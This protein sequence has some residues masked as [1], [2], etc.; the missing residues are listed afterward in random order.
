MVTARAITRWLPAMVVLGLVLV[1]AYRVGNAQRGAS[2]ETE[3]ARQILEAS[4]VKGGLIVHVGCGDGRLTAALCANDSYVVH[5]L[6][7]N[8]GNIERAREHIRSL[9]LYGKVSVERRKGKRLPYVDNLVNL[10]VSDGRARVSM[11]EVMRVLCPNGVAYIKKGRKWTKAVKPRP[12]EIDAWTHYLHDA[13]NNAVAHDSVVGPPR[14]MQWVGSPRWARHHDRM[15]SLTALVSTGSRIFYI[16]DEGP[17]ASVQLPPKWTL[18]A[19]DAFNGAILWKRPIPRW[20]PH[21]YPFKSGP[22]YLPRRLVAVG[23]T[24]YVTLGLEAPLT[25]LDA[26]TGE[27]IQ[28]YEGT[29]ATEEVI[30]SDGVLFLLVDETPTDWN[31]FKPLVNN[32]GEEKARVARDWPWDEKNRRIVAI[33]ADTGKGLWQKEYPVVP[34]TLAADGE[35]VAFHDGEAIVCL[36]RRSG[37]TLWRSEPVSRRPSIP[38]AFGPTLV[39][40]EDVVLFSG[41]DRRQAGLSAQTG[42]TLWTAEHPRSGHNSPEDLLVVNGLAW[43]GAIAS[44]RESGV[45]AGRDVHTGEVKNEFAPNVETYWFHHRCY[46]AKAT[47]KYILPSRTGIEFVDVRA[48]SWEIH[49]WVR[50]GCIYG[51]MPCN[52][53][54]YAP[55]HDCACYAEAKLYGFNALAPE[56]GAGPYPRVASDAARLERGPAYGKPVSG[57]SASTGQDEWPTYRHD[58]TRGGFTKA[59]VPANLKRAWQTD[60]GGKISSVVIAGGK[61]FVASVDTHT[62]HALDASSGKALW[63][64]TAGGRV[65]SPPTIY[66]GR[67]LFGSADGWVYS[68][69]TSDGALIWRFRAAPQDRKV[70]AFEQLESVWPVHGSVLVQDGVLYCVAGRSV[71]LD[72]GLHLLQLD[73]ETGRKLSETVLDDRDPETG[74]NLQ[75]RIQILNM[76]VALPDVLSSD[77]RHVYM[78]SQVFDLQGVRQELGPHSGNPAEQGSVQAGETAHLFAPMGFVDGSWFHRAY[79]VYGRSFAGGHGGYHQAGRFAPAG[80]ILAVDDSSVYGYGRLPEYYRW[81]TPL[82]YH[83]FATSRDIPRAEVRAA[84][85]GRSEVQIANSPSL[86]PT[87]KPLA[88]E[89]WVKADGRDGVVLARGGP[90]HGYALIVRDGKPRFV[91]RSDEKVSSAP[92]RE[93]VVGKWAHLAGVLTADRQ[94]R[95]YVNGELAG[96]AEASA[97][98]ASDPKQAMEIGADQGGA[99]GE[100][101]S[102]FGLIGVIDEVRVYFRALSA[103]EIQ[104]HY[105]RPGPPPAGEHGL[106]LCLSFDKGDATD[107]SGN[108]NDGTVAGAEPTDGRLGK[109]MRFTGSRTRGV[110]FAVTHDWSQQLPLMVRAMVLADKTLFIA[111][112]PDVVD[113]EESFSSFDDPAIQAKLKEQSAALEGTRGALLWAVSTSDG[114]KLAEYQLESLPEWDGMAAANG[115]LYL[116]TTDGKVLCFAGA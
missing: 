43:S 61:L 51:I 87:G 107:D 96:S 35:R 21:L 106:V 89:A 53:L 14:R 74:A 68:L 9:N 20:H 65:D 45:F 64:Y 112:P 71:F 101:K 39:L 44:G 103:D 15:A 49:H 69:R 76:P 82:E 29:Q 34:L 59:S 36:D 25:A 28:T 80:R 48:N 6:D 55:M 13:S 8:L 110:Q 5:G 98:I 27:T 1:V 75:A 37:E 113:E 23:E 33:Q 104:R 63:S 83:L 88:V 67:V 114:E 86:D 17:T 109:A 31:E 4:G 94:L 58:A 42:E 38:T 99:V 78:K 16:F 85:G 26:A 93:D 41:G 32:V 18:I 105:E 73:P 50:G 92:A 11:G 90:S 52:G 108:K 22:A 12:E 66:Q 116:S 10:L 91:I 2:A 54:I 115:R 30:A 57:S 72:G 102:P 70:M 24:V 19:R 62:V 56:S 7:R 84:S 77:G 60:L 100:Y 79:W 97:L 95:I 40:Y 111:G 47:D 3:Q 81:T 46:R